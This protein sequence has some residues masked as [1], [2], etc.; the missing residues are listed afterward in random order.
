MHCIKC[1]KSETRVVDSRDDGKTVR[2]RRECFSCNF[3]FTTYEKS[4]VP[5][6]KVEKR[7]GDK[8][9]YKREKIYHGIK[10]SLEKRPFSDDKINLVVD[11]IE[12]KIIALQ[13]SIV[14][15]QIIGKIV[16][17]ELKKLD[18]VAYL[19]FMSVYKSFSSAKSFASEA[20]KLTSNKLSL[21]RRR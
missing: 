10:K 3:R 1:K 20:S 13:K 5:V 19:R 17:K 21:K 4:E 2:R 15:S 9:G 8:E 11:D 12:Q 18:E 6:F 14:P 16:S 7:N